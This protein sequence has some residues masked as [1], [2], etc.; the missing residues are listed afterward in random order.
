MPNSVSVLALRAKF[1]DELSEAEARTER[2]ALDDEIVEHDLRYHQEDRPTIS[3]ADY[4]K[5]RRRFEE[6]EARFPSLAGEESRSRSVGAP[7]SEKFSKI[8]HRVPMLSL[9]NAFADDEVLEFVARVRRFLDLD[10]GSTPAF[11]AEPKIDGL[12]CAIRYERGKLT[13]AATR[14][15]GEVG[16][17][18]TA[19]VRTIRAI[20]GKLNGDVP[21]VLEVR[22]EVYL[23]HADFAKINER[24]AERGKQV[25]ANPRNAAAGSLRQLDPAVTARRPLQF[26]AYG[27]GE[28]SALPA[29]TQ[30]GVVEAFAGFGLP[31]NKMMRLCR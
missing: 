6:I 22:G 12:S 19:N 10:A 5:L 8:R 13:R 14:G 16:E 27:W 25:F 26:F 4:D 15:D 24:Q 17:D 31:T 28:V 1:V 9:G 7:P 20:P 21:E 3:D 29:S 2:A 30:S 11:T 23:R 18:V